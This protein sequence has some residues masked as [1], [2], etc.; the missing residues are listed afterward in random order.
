[1]KTFKYSLLTMFLA[2]TAA[3]GPLFNVEP[4]PLVGNNGT[5]GWG[6]TLTNDTTSYLSVD[7]LQVFSPVDDPLFRF[8]STGNFTELFATYQF[9]AANILI[10]PN[11]T[12]T[13]DYNGADQGLATWT[14]P[15]GAG[16]NGG[17][18]SNIFQI[19]LGYSLYDDDAY[20]I[21][22]LDGDNNAITGAIFAD[23][24][25]QFTDASAPEPSTWFLT[26]TPLALLGVRRLRLGL[27]GA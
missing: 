1:M 13:L 27:I 18:A 9:N 25:L 15:D 21:A 16:A 23:A 12:Y 22:T 20:S 3:A 2:A 4:T 5:Y 19:R 7:S 14:F 26:V 10:T 17:L 8:G 24:Q 11:S 6:F